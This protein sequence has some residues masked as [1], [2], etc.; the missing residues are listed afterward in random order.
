MTNFRELLKQVKSEIGETTPEKVRERLRLRE[1]V[2]ILDV[3][4]QEEVDQGMVPGAAHLGRAHLESRVEDVIPDKDAPVILYCASGVRSAF[5]AKTL[6]E[7][8]YLR[9]ES[10]AGGFSRW[11]EL[12]FEQATVRRLDASQR[13]RYSRHILL[14][15]VGEEG[16]LKF[17]D[18]KVLCIGAGGLGSP[19]LLYLAAAGVGTIGIVDADIV[20]ASNLQRQIIHDIDHI[21][22]PK[23]ESA[24]EAIEKLNPDVR[25]VTHQER[26][27]ASN[28]KELLTQYDLVVDGSDNFDTRYVLND[29][30]VELRKPVVHGSIFRFEGMVSTFVPFEG[31]CYSCLY[32]EAPPPELAPSCSEAGVLGVL[33]GIVGSLQA[34]EALKLIGGHGDPLIGRLLTFDAHATQ[35]GEVKVRRDPN[36]P[37]CGEGATQDLDSEE[38]TTAA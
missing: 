30:A 35:F 9:V 37:V 23:V 2:Q 29:A 24:R 17:L 26:I 22:V 20:D 8:G 7:L 4:E 18:A 38:E 11:K 34:N 12:G 14:P 13:E 5:A 21:D 33:P 15:D 10:M 16:Q 6:G 27:D 3:R 31:P 32:P 1:P 28:A 25:V 19:A 36:C